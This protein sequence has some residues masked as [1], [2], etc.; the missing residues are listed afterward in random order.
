MAAASKTFLTM[1]T[2][3]FALMFGGGVY[4]LSKIDTLAKPMAER[5]ASEA[6][7]VRV[8][9]GAMTISLPEKRVDVMNIRVANPQGFSKPHA[10]TIDNTRIALKNV[11]TKLIDFEGIG[12]SGAKVFLEVNE[13][14]TNLHALKKGMK[15]ADPQTAE[16]E[17][18]KVIIRHFVLNR[19]QLNPSVTLIESQD[20]KPIEVAPVELK[21]IGVKE[22]GILAREAVTQIMAPLLQTFSNAAGDAGFYQ[23]L[24][25]D[26]LKEI[27]ASQI[28]QIKT[29]INEEVDKIGE[30]LKNLF[31]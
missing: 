24:S 18:L 2:V 8:S 11:A 10:L 9:I 31:Q 22:N 20:L 14:G 3:A 7:G 6:L 12:V 23:G 26:A 17:P 4:V 30:G 29:Q 19:T 15:G 25:S 5:I 28:N 27:G 1:T 13:S 16:E 21:G